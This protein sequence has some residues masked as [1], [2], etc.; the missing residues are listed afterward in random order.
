MRTTPVVV[1]EEYTKDQ[2]DE[3]LR[4]FEV[5]LKKSGLR[6]GGVQ[7]VL[8]KGNLLISDT[9]TL[10]QRLGNPEN[11]FANEVAKQVWLYPRGWKPDALEIQAK[12]ITEGLSGFEPKWRDV[13]GLVIPDIADGIC[14]LPTLKALGKHWSIDAYRAIGECIEATYAALAALRSTTNYRHGEL[15][16]RYVRLPEGWLDAVEPLEREV[17]S[18]GENCLVLPF[19]FG[20]WKTGECYSPRNAT[21]QALNLSPRRFP[22]CAVQ[23]GTSL[24]AMPGRLTDWGQLFIDCCDQYDWDAAGI[25]AYSLYVRFFGGELEMDA[26]AARYAYG[27]SRL[28][29]ALLGES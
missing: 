24:I 15:T 18:R 6:K 12:N 16:N 22:F 7:R 3:L 25:W 11:P 27:S 8:G 10:L 2:K 29:V 13:S 23:V 28:P 19:H 14:I 9:M 5:A 26:R 1:D 17:E 21:W 4:Q 20:D